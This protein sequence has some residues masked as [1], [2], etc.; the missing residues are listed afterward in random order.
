MISTKGWQKGYIGFCQP[1][2]F[3]NASIY[4]EIF[5]FIGIVPFRL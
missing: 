1:F 3:I 5:I 2:L 4:D